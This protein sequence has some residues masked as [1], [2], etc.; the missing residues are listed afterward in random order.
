V[1]KALV[2]RADALSL[3]FPKA[4]NGWLTLVAWNGLGKVIVDLSPTSG[5]LLTD[6]TKG[7]ALNCGTLNDNHGEVSFR[8]V[9]SDI[10]FQ[11]GMVHFAGADRLRFW[12]C[13]GSYPNATWKAQFDTA[14]TNDGIAVIA[15]PPNTSQYINEQSSVYLKNNFTATPFRFEQGLGAFECTNIWFYNC[16]VTAAGDDG[17]YFGNTHVL[18]FRGNRVQNVFGGSR[19]DTPGNLMYVQM[20]N[21]AIRTSIA[22]TTAAITQADGFAVVALGCGGAIGG[23]GALGWTNSFTSSYDALGGARGSWPSRATPSRK[24][25][26]KTLH[27]NIADL[28][29]E[30]VS[31]DPKAM[32]YGTHWYEEA[33]LKKERTLWPLRTSL[34]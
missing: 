17:Y 13:T 34:R 5:S 2:F 32:D 33:H 15:S 9:F 30:A 12:H 11:N 14:C 7:G 29:H 27:D 19:G 20:H 4:N 1:H 3:D 10:A 26:P 24:A 6:F 8:I 22:L 25:D 31:S 23:T 28:Y 21:D 18:R 16:D